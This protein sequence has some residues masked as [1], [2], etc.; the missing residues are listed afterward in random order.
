MRLK[1]QTV[2]L[3]KFILFLLI[4]TEP[5]QA[6]LL[7]PRYVGEL[8][9]S[10]NN[11]IEELPDGI[12]QSILDRIVYLG[13]RD[14]HFGNGF[15]INSQDILTC[16][17]VLVRIAG[18][19]KFLAGLRPVIFPSNFEMYASA[20]V[21]EL[22]KFTSNDIDFLSLKTK[23]PTLE[24]ML[25]IND[26]SILKLP[27]IKNAEISDSENVFETEPLIEGEQVWIIGYAFPNSTLSFTT[28]RLKKDSSGAFFIEGLVIKPGFSGSPVVRANGKVLG[29]INTYYPDLKFSTFVSWQRVFETNT[30]SQ[31]YQNVKSD[32]VADMG[33]QSKLTGTF[34]CESSFGNKL[35]FL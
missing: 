20:E 35:E 32:K 4:C 30:S 33:E 29:I 15:R 17:H 25:K 21:K 19:T 22:P 8:V 10:S 3:L 2:F 14:G 5:S 23:A 24:T 9:A 31:L 13:G 11:P 1:Q 6:G 28:G 7:L 27:A 16:A 34:R 12:S 18:Q 26:W